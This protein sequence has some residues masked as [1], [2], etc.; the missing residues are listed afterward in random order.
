MMHSERYLRDR[1][2]FRI[3]NIKIFVGSPIGASHGSIPFL[4]VLLNLSGVEEKVNQRN[5][6]R[7]PHHKHDIEK[8]RVIEVW[9]R[10]GFPFAMT[11]G[12][13]IRSIT[14]NETLTSVIDPEAVEGPGAT[15]EVGRNRVG[16]HAKLAALRYRRH[17]AER[18]FRIWPT[19]NPIFREKS[20][21]T[22]RAII[23]L[24]RADRAP[25]VGASFALIDFRKSVAKDTLQALVLHWVIWVFFA[26]RNFEIDW[27]A[28][29]RVEEAIV[30]DITN[31]IR[32][33]AAQRVVRTAEDHLERKNQRHYSSHQSFIS[34][35]YQ[36]TRP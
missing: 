1:I 15:G 24:R 33:T 9:N 2:L 8:P 21:E 29:V 25:A 12:R 14:T 16:R 6:D 31:V 22:S 26:M 36:T 13:Y 32:T 28:I 35:Y 34:L 23:P 30:A 4:S 18:I 11:G 7:R 27:M 5:R 10:L 20:I 17:D 3:L 19:T